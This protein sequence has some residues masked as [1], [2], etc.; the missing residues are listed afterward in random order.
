MDGNQQCEMG[1]T[2]RPIPQFSSVPI[3]RLRSLSGFCFWPGASVYAVMWPKAVV[4]FS[5]ENLKALDRRW[6]SSA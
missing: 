2:M 5:P 6:G 4:P 1:D 3:S